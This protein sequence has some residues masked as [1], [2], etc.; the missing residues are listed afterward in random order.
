MTLKGGQLTII[1]IVCC[2]LVCC[3]LNLSLQRYVSVFSKSTALDNDD[4]EITS[5]SEA[6]SESEKDVEEASSQH[7]H[8]FKRSQYPQLISKRHKAYEKYR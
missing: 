7:Q 5:E 3:V 6:G 2:V 8:T 1:V 4:E